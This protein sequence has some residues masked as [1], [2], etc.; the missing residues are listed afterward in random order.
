M[1]NLSQDFP[2]PTLPWIYFLTPPLLPYPCLAYQECSSPQSWIGI[3]ITHQNVK[4]FDLKHPAGNSVL[5]K[6]GKASCI[7]EVERRSTVMK[8][9]QQK[10]R[11]QLQKRDRRD[12]EVSVPTPAWLDCFFLQNIK[13]YVE[14]PARK[15]LN[16][17]ALN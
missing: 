5:T 2:S 4:N 10:K 9:M 1:C 12:L 15:L 7:C 17:T 6:F 11:S 16:C 3:F 13:P 14:Q 8:N